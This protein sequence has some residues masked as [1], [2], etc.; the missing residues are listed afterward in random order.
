MATYKGSQRPSKAS[1]ARLLAVQVGSYVRIREAFVGEILNKA[2]GNS[3]LS[4][5]DKAFATNLC[6]GVASTLGTLD[7]VINKA[8][9]SPS[10]IQ[11]DVRDA[12]R[13]STYEI[14]YLEKSS[15]AAVDQG[16]ELVRSFAPKACGV[17]NFALRK[18]N[19]MKADFP[20]GDPEK[21]IEAAA[22]LY[23]FPLWMAKVLEKSLGW[24]KAR[25]FMEA[26]NLAAPL[27]IAINSINAIDS[28]VCDV[29]SKAR[30]ELA[31]V[32]IDGITIAGCYRV[33][34]PTVLQ[35]PSI[36]KLFNEGKILVS[37]AASQMVANL[38]IGSG[39]SDSSPSKTTNETKAP[40]VLEIGSGRATKSILLQSNAHRMH[41]S[42]LELSCLDT[43]SYKMD[44]LKTRCVTYGTHVSATHVGDGRKLSQLLNISSDYS[45]EYDII[46]ID[47][48]CS[49]L[50]TL[51]RH[52]EIRWRITPDQISQMA[53]LGLEILE[54][55]ASH[56]SIGGT[57]AY[58]T[59]T[60]L[61]LE[62]EFT[63][64]KFLQ[65][66]AGENF[67][68]AH[69]KAMDNSNEVRE[70]GSGL[71]KMQISKDSPDAHFLAIIK[72]IK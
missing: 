63:I 62:N 33:I 39:I 37:D 22:L 43:H 5:P 1:P 52:P 51:R 42:Q 46:F 58:A 11:D 64:K 6:L 45:K 16:V 53:A 49:G 61:P 15:H 72:R 48:P 27:F 68:L 41:S 2:L 30:C 3:R 26:S 14:L 13:I 40:K 47:A 35:D 24:N 7:F 36:T 8:L 44:I 4:A 21:S 60:V 55:A 32:V 69:M 31:P 23:A 25:E 67:K 56:V 19:S 12:L 9:K 66:K 38:V 17:A 28:Y 34:T 10:D 18:I 65:S 57:L 50:G 29:F 59:C 71:F 70:F 54:A 20:F